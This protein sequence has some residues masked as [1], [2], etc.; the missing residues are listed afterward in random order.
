MSITRYVLRLKL[1]ESL[2]DYSLHGCTWGGRLAKGVGK[3][4]AK[5]AKFRIT[6]YQLMRV[7][8]TTAGEIPIVPVDISLISQTML[9]CKDDIGEASSPS[10]KIEEK[11][12]YLQVALLYFIYGKAD[13]AFK[14]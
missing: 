7:T 5:M 4:T 3:L 14:I 9:P 1:R 2:S 8:N 11:L 10:Q 6:V 13:R 12:Q